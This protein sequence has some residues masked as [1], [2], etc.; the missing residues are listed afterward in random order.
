MRWAALAVA[1]CVAIPVQAQEHDAGV[2]IPPAVVLD[3][4]CWLPTERCV[5]VGQ[6]LV[7]LREENTALKA[8]R[9]VTPTEAVFAF[10]VGLVVGGVVAGVAVSVAK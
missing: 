3:G 6:E 5:L 9:P 8:K 2:V 1:V 7:Q 10:V 4:G